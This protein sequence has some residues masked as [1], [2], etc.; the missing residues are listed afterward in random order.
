MA[1]EKTT[2][3]CGHEGAMQLYGKQSGR[4]A[5]V[6]SQAGRDC[7]ACWL[8]GQWE[9]ENDP[10]AKREDR[11]K[12]AGDIAEGKGKRIYGLPESVPAKTSESTNPLA[13]ISTANLLAEITRRRETGEEIAI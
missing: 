1:W 7:M 10:R 2:W 6:A 9:K 13:G 11:Y 4:D 3:A 12:L 8:V 5:T